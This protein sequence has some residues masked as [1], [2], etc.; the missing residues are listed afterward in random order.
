MRIFFTIVL[1]TGLATI[2]TGS[3]NA[4]PANID[5]GFRL[6]GSNASSNVLEYH[7][8]DFELRTIEENGKILTRPVIP[9]SGSLVM[10]GEPDLP[11]TTTFYAVEPG[12]S[13]SLQVTIIAS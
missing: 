11:S 5:D 7:I 2:L 13:Y 6:K 12:I 4:G 10:P 1:G 3:E 9:H 8:P